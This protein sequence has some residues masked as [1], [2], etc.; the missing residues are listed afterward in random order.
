MSELYTGDFLANFH[1]ADAPDFDSWRVVQ[2]ERRHRQVCE[3]LHTL[4]AHY[5]L[6]GD[7]PRIVESPGVWCNWN[8]GSRSVIAI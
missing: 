7:Y 6:I 8:P 4:I 2:Q 1:V 3:A 5:N